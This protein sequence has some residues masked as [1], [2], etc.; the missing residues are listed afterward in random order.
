MRLNLPVS[1]IEFPLPDGVIIVTKTD[2][3]GAIT[4]C[5]QAFVE[6][7]GRSR[8]E[9][10][11]APHNI[12]RHPDMPPEA[13]ADLWKT[14][15]A[16]KPWQG[17]VKNRRKD[18]S[19][20]WAVSNVTPLL[21]KGKAIGY[22]AFRYKATQEQ[23][24]SA[25]AAY[26]QIRDGSRKLHIEEGSVI[27]VKSPLLNW[28]SAA[29]VK[30]RLF[31]LIFVLLGALVVTGIFNLYESSKAH[32]HTVEGFAATSVQTYAL[33][34]AR[35]AESAFKEQRHAWKNILIR[36]RDAALSNRYIEEFD[37]RGEEVEQILAGQLIPIM[38]QIGLSTDEVVALLESH[39]LMINKY[40]SALALSDVRK[41]G[42]IPA[43]DTLTE[44]ADQR[45]TEQFNAIIATI[46]EAQL[47]SL[48][49][50]NDAMEK[51]YN[52]QSNRSTAILVAFALGGLLLST[53]F[54]I[55]ILR[56]I[57]R[58]SSN[59]DRVV[60]LQQQF[61]EKILALEEQNDRI[62]EEQRIGSHIMGRITNVHG[63]LDPLIR[64]LVRPAEHLSG[65]MLLAARTPDDALHILLADAVGHGLVAAI[66]VLPLSQSFY[67]MTGNG[68]RIAQ[69][70]EELN[71]KINRFMPVDRFVAA[72]LI[73]INVCNR[74]IEVWNGGNPAPLLVSKNGEILHEWKSTNLPL[75]ILPSESFSGKPEVFQYEANCQLCLFS[76]GLPEAESPSGEPFSKDRIGKS[77]RCSAPNKR[78]DALMAELDLHLAG[79]LAHDDI[80]LA[81]VEIPDYLRTE[82]VPAAPAPI[83]AKP[84]G[85]SHWKIEISLDAAELKYLNIIPMLTNIIEKIH[86][87]NEFAAPLYIILSELF[88][89]ALDHGILRLDSGIKHGVDGFDKFLQLRDERLHA[90]DNGKIDLEIEKV[91]IEGQYG[92]KIRVA[93]SGNGFNYAEILGD[94]GNQVKRGQHG[95]GILLVESMAHKLEYAGNG[96]EV[97]AYYI[98]A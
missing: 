9:I 67:D 57:R 7:S 8:K 49:D 13:F 48:G 51:S 90:L 45:I 18:G 38:Q 63:T 94:A 96:N 89:N 98:C 83:Q 80:S 59:L 46:R 33:A 6:I 54:I 1:N 16:D 29:S 92:V 40:H 56:P 39:I 4:Y 37:R 10:I 2:L 93:D 11:G 14:I 24:E 41:L 44:G 42:N 31:S 82:A 36:G 71:L 3:K 22:V 60:Q 88:N 70:A 91:V 30:A 69:I 47:R 72:T 86:I 35:S 64:H 81:M 27:R 84:E 87:T 77:L 23:I 85:G 20:Y 25:S 78:F 34:T 19:F 52:D 76:D 75:G 15:K 28:L 62:D 17:V 43:L 32:K 5:N 79:G 66:N 26:Q 95:R 74:V 12:V 50:L 58:A 68:F 53:W 61:L 97:T 73:S 65:D 55:G 21:E